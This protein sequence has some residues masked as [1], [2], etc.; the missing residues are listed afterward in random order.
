ME[1]SLLIV[2]REV[3]EAALVVSIVAA[4][5][6]GVP[7][8][9]RWISGGI[10]AGIIGSLIVAFFANLIVTNDIGQ[11]VAVPILGFGHRHIDVEADFLFAFGF[12]AIGADIGF[13]HIK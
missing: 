7:G 6:K 13:G 12:V 2:F 4:V 3:M 1:A 9:K 8:R 5:T 11:F 10:L